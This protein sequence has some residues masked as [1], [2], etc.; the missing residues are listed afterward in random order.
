MDVS[1]LIPNILTQTW[2]FRSVFSDELD[3]NL[4]AL[5]VEGLLVLF[6]FICKLG[7]PSI[8]DYVQWVFLE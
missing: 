1:V 5:N 3:K 6:L 8:L 7:F 4:F 2:E